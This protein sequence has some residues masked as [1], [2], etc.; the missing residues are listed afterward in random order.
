MI[1]GVNRFRNVVDWTFQRPDGHPCKKVDGTI[2]TGEK[3]VDDLDFKTYLFEMHSYAIGGEMEASG[4][5]AAASKRNLEWIIVKAVCDWA[6]GTK[7]DGHQEVAA[8]AAASLV[9]HTLGRA[10]MIANLEPP[11]PSRGQQTPR[12]LKPP[13]PTASAVISVV[14]ERGA[15]MPGPDATLE[16]TTWL[17]RHCG[18]ATRMLGE[19][20]RQGPK[21]YFYDNGSSAYWDEFYALIEMWRTWCSALITGLKRRLNHAEHIIDDAKA[22]FSDSW[23]LRITIQNW[24]EPS[25]KRTFDLHD[26]TL[27]TFGDGSHELRQWYGIGREDPSWSGITQGLRYEVDAF[28]R[29]LLN[30]VDELEFALLAGGSGSGRS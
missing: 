2:L 20:F 13:P 22:R 7:G 17:Q 27:F 23:L 4:V 14:D 24:R 11:R 12:A 8:E 16:F 5:Y 19:D 10:N 29:M 25:Q 1:P 6:D 28:A 15:A 30:Q 18:T 26:R 9:A 3:L 21:Y